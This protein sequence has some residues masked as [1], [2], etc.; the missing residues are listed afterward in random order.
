MDPER[1]WAD[2][3]PTDRISYR[4][5]PKNPCAA[6]VLLFCSLARWML[7]YTSEIFSNDAQV[8]CDRYIYAMLATMLARGRQP[9]PWLIDLLPN[10]RRPDAA[11]HMDVDLETCIARIRQRKSFEDAYVEREHLIRSL[12]SYRAIARDFGM[13]TIH[14]SRHGIDEAFSIAWRIVEQLGGEPA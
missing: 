6:R 13:H 7:F 14:S 4:F 2:L 9:E 3:N 1:W 12:E 11:F 8:L 10:I 5:V